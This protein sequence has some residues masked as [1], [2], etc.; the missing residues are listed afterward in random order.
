MLLIA[1]YNCSIS[2]VIT[3]SVDYQVKSYDIPRDT[4]LDSML[5]SEPIDSYRNYKNELV[6]WIFD[7]IVAEEWDPDFTEG[8]EIIGF[9]T[10]KPI[11]KIDL[12]S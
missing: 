4:D 11:E 12:N 6:E 8:D 3:N 1:R 9:I 2:G 7:E 10:G 5:K